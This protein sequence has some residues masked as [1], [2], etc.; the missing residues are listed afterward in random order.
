MRNLL[1]IPRMMTTTSMNIRRMNYYDNNSNQIA[2]EDE[3]YLNWSPAKPNSFDS[4]QND[5]IIKNLRNFYHAAP[6]PNDPFVGMSK[7]PLSEDILTLLRSPPPAADIRI[8]RN[9]NLYVLSSFYPDLLNRTFGVGGWSI[10]PI[11]EPTFFQKRDGSRVISREFGLYFLGGF[12]VMGL[13]E[14][15]LYHNIGYK[16]GLSYAFEFAKREALT[17]CCK[18][19]GMAKNIYEE[20]FV[21]KWRDENAETVTCEHLTTKL[22]KQFWFKKGSDTQFTYPWQ[23]VNT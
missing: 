15:I 13:G 19:L 22:T 3:I 16:S 12:M 21:N 1:V 8:K 18:E 14:G 23:R 17:L 20:E 9:G 7:E 11:S 5:S 2:D 6:K 10:N 4:K